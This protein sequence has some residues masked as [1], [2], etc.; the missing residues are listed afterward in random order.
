M[1]FNNNI[2]RIINCVTINIHTGVLREKVENS[3]GVN[4]LNVI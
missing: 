3:F 1:I 4:F 2:T